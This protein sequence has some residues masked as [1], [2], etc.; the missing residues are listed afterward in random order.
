MSLTASVRHVLGRARHLHISCRALVAASVIVAV[1]L[2]LL[3]TNVLL[4]MRRSDLEK[5]RQASENLVATIAADIA[6]NIELYDLSLQAVADNL[7]HPEINRVSKDL[8]QLILF[9]RA[10]TA[11]HLGSIRVLDTTGHVVLDSRTIDVPSID[12]SEGDYFKIHRE[13]AGVGLYVGRPFVGSRGN[14]NIGISRRLSNPDGSFAGVVAGTLRLGYF[15]DLFRKVALGPES[16]LSLFDTGGTVLM[17]TP[18]NIDDIGRDLS[19]GNA[20]KRA[21]TNKTGHFEATASIDGVKRL[22]VFRQV[23]GL[24][25]ILMVG[26]S[27]DEIYSH[28]RA[29]AWNVSVIGLALGLATIALAIFAAKELRRRT[30]AE[31]QF[32]ALAATDGL[33]GLVNRR[34]FNDLLDKEWKRALRQRTPIALLMIDA[35]HFKDYNDSH[36]HQAGDEAL[37]A[38][39]NCIASETRDATDIAGRYGGEEFVVLLPGGTLDQA[40]EMAERI[41]TAIEKQSASNS[42]T[43]HLPTVSIGVTCRIPSDNEQ[44][45]GLI[46][47]ADHALYDAKHNG[48]NRT[49][50]AQHATPRDATLSIAA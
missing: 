39:A 27:L 37:V 9:D 41:R 7:R 43:Y 14:Y 44:S 12:F 28:W 4:E 42:Q 45:S 20:F 16:S 10:A 34:R 31:K 48:R 2:W 38:I 29:E 1:A 32:A 15:H 40:T 11:K 5:A 46:A 24:P 25:L 21:M 13:N 19:N 26:M 8:R 22:F 36:G 18:F 3:G 35:D 6:R 17:R 50:V 23:R 47:G 30:A 33:T 49:E